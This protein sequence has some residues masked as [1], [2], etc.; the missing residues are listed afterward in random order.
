MT[1]FKNRIL[2]NSKQLTEAKEKKRIQKGYD[3]HET[4]SGIN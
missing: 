4:P 2:V 3:I 1:V